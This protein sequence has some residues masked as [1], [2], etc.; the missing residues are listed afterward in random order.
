VN[1]QYRVMTHRRVSAI[2]LAMACLLQ[3]A[4]VDGQESTRPPDASVGEIVER[5]AFRLHK[6]AQP[7]GE[8]T[9]QI[10]KANRSFEL[11]TSFKFTDR[12]SAV[13]L[14]AKLIF[15]AD[16][17]PELFEVKGK[18]SRFTDIDDAVMVTM[19][20]VHVRQDQ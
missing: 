9:F 14:T 8:E 7:I 6:F 16:L 1:G 19:R 5:G 18:N 13:P 3:S 11:T 4:V 20:N 17:T 10:R 12:G 15:G 2:S